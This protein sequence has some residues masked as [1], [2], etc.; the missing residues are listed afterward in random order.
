M[1]NEGDHHLTLLANEVAALV[2][3]KEEELVLQL[4]A[5]AAHGDLRSLR[6]LMQSGID[7]NVGDFDGRRPLVSIRFG[8][9]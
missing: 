8:N 7:P 5:A 3:K 6:Q 1:R 9:V 4:C 2:G